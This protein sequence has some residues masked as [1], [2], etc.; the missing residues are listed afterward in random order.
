[1]TQAC[2]SFWSMMDSSEPASHLLRAC[3]AVA[4]LLVTDQGQ[5]L[6]Q[7]R[8]D[9]SNIW[10]PGYWGLFGGAVD[11]GESPEDALCRELSEEISFNPES[12]T[13][14]TN[15]TFDFGFVGQGT[16]FRKFYEVPIPSM[17]LPEL[18]LHEGRE[19]R[20][21]GPEEVLA[22]ARIVP[23]DAFALNLHINRARF[24]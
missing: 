21:F 11:E 1:M 6:L 8:D 4:A 10:Y 19:I 23:Y 18:E 7:L 14:F 16:F 15:F 3:D 5:Y 17:R 13:H 20:S 12:F 22:L 24:A 9:K 2:L